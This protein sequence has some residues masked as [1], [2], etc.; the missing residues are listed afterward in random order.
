MSAS[1]IRTRTVTIYSG[2][3]LWSQNDEKNLLLQII[4]KLSSYNTRKPSTPSNLY[5]L[6]TLES[7]VDTSSRAATNAWDSSE[8]FPQGMQH[9]MQK[10]S[11][12]VMD[13][14]IRAAYRG[15]ASPAFW[16]VR[17]H[18]SEIGKNEGQWKIKI[19]GE[20][21]QK[22]DSRSAVIYI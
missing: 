22:E 12:S 1:S 19:K 6:P 2:I 16:S 13:Y 21:W 4:E 14:Y 10:Y 8:N 20:R 9:S 17:D 18:C 7:N 11:G 3:V 5:S 15:R